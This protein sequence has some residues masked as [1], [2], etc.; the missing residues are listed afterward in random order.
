MSAPV[1]VA[2]SQGAPLNLLVLVAN[3]TYVHRSHRTATHRKSSKLA[4][5]PG[6]PPR[7]QHSQQTETQLRSFVKDA[8]SFIFKLW[9]EGHTKQHLEADY[10]A[11]QNWRLADSSFTLFLCLTL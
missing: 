9:P 4:I 7:A 1:W 8:Y 2:A 5:Y 3:R 10:N 6:P 11:V